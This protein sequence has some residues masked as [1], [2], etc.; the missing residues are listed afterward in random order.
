MS[1]KWDAAA[2]AARKILGKDGKVPDL[3]AA[4]DKA[5]DSM[6]KASGE[7]DK[8]ARGL[9]GQARCPAERQ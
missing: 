7:L 5:G 1:A 3:P 9:R 4:V 6:F 8:G 2:A